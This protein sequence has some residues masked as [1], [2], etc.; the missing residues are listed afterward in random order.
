[1]T[2]TASQCPRAVGECESAVRGERPP[3][4]PG[5]TL[6]QGHL[7]ALGSD[8]LALFQ[9]CAALGGIVRFRVYAYQCHVITNP[10]LAGALLM[11]ESASFRKPR[12]LQAA[13][14]TFGNGLV[15]SEG[16][17]WRRQQRWLRKFFTPRAAD[18]YG[19]LITTV[20]ERKLDRWSSGEIVDLHEEILDVSLEVVCRALFGL[21]ASRLK[22]LIRAA[23]EAVQGWH[24]ACLAQCLPYPHLLP[25]R[26]NFRYRR[27]TWPLDRAVYALIREAR[28]GGG[29]GHGL[30]GGMLAV[31]DEQD[32]S[33]ITDREIRDQVVT[34][35]LAGHDTTASSLSF[36]L[37]ELSHCPD[38]QARIADDLRCGSESGALELSIKEALRLYPAVHIVGRTALRDVR[39]GRYLVRKGEEVLV[40]LYVM[41]RSPKLFPRPEAFEPERWANASAQAACPRHAHIPFSVGARVCI[42]QALAMVELRT[43][44]SAVLR[45]FQLAPLGPRAP[46][47][48]DGITLAP[49]P[50]ST[51]VRVAAH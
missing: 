39:L 17:Q 18:G 5:G 29:A 24:K 32:G 37:Y 4:L 43:M 12:G 2:E 48:A 46:R 49:A 3:L 36:A 28:A 10:E 26:A 27:L 13:R 51:R 1:M 20:I 22:P 6:V 15:T 16:E 25:T 45:R 35:F 11:G 47:I 44:I 14:P 34:L 19:E 50:T 42:G 33:R 40:P 23:A 41:Q 31:K 38:L 7:H 21:D 9:R 30:L 8:S